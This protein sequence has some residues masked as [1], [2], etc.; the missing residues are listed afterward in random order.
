M[1]Q[2]FKAIESI[3]TPRGELPKKQVPIKVV[4]PEDQF[5]DFADTVAVQST[6]Q[7]FILSFLQLQP[8]LVLS[9]V[10]VE[11]TEFIETVCVSRIV[12]TVP[13]VM[14]LVQALQQEL[15]NYTNKAMAAPKAG[16]AQEKKAE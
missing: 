11:Q 5:L 12:L 1:A 13:R 3:Q 9:S 14:E 8:P 7:E 15:Q 2:D 16:S 10:D 6:E 4:I